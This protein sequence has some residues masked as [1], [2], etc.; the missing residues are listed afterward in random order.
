MEDENQIFVPPSFMAVYSDA[1]G[2]LQAGADAVRERYGLCEDLASDLVEQAQT[3]YH[4]QAP[5][6]F[7]ILRRIHAGLSTRNKKKVAA[8][9]DDFKVFLDGLQRG[10][11]PLPVEPEAPVTAEV[12][13]ER[14]PSR[15]TS[16]AVTVHTTDRLTKEQ[17]E[18]FDEALYNAFKSNPLVKQGGWHEEGLHFEMGIVTVSN[19]DATEG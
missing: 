18:A 17:H 16:L 8:F 15:F 7:E 13:S 5:S 10:A 9:I 6:E 19:A 2:R 4:V 12:V 1:R 14:W 3:L 11:N